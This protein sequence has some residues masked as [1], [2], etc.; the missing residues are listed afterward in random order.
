VII[1]AA[2]QAQ[3]ASQLGA[4]RAWSGAVLA[5][6]CE[7]AAPNSLILLGSLVR[8][9]PITLNREADPGLVRGRWTGHA[10]REWMPRFPP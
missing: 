1:F 10:C 3:L 8:I 5:G 7:L 9:M 4:W 2:L 6:L